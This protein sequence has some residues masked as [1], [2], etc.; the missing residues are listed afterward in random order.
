MCKGQ[1][2]QKIHPSPPKKCLRSNTGASTVKLWIKEQ[3][4][5]QR[6]EAEKQ[7]EDGNGMGHYVQLKAMSIL[8][9]S[10]KAIS[11]ILFPEL[12][13]MELGFLPD[14]RSK[15]GRGGGEGT[16]ERRK[17]AE[18]EKILRL[19][20]CFSGHLPTYPSRSSK[21]SNVFTLLQD[22]WGSEPPHPAKTWKSNGSHRNLVTSSLYCS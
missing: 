5:M 12:T 2:K 9:W 15:E 11:L 8:V 17:E 1:E 13:Q 6:P 20:D 4:K 18:K 22:G 10:L 3:S 16:G 19:T 21:G 7:P 14:L